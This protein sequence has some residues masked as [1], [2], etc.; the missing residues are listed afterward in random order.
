[1]HTSLFSRL[2]VIAHSVGMDANNPEGGL[3]HDAADDVII[4]TICDI[5]QGNPH[6]LTVNR[7]ELTE[8]Q[9]HELVQAFLTM[10]YD[11]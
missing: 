8:R 2:L 4:E 11:R 10:A 5:A 3:H 1:M 7:D 9:E 6:N